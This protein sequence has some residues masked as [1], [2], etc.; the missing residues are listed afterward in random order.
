MRWLRGW[1]RLRGNQPG[2]LFCPVRKNGRVATG[3]GLTTEALAQI[4]KR[5]CQQAGIRQATTWHDLRRSFAGNLLDEGVDLVTVQNLMGHV[6][7]ATTASYDRRP[8]RV[9]LKAAQ[10]IELPT[11]IGE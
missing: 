8:A 1:L 9:R 11:F 3:K 2:P 4:L 10:R 6:S 7:P 5:R